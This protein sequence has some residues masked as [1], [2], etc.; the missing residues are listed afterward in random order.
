MHQTLTIDGH[1]LAIE[2][3][4]DGHVLRLIGPDGGQRIEI[5]LTAAGPLLRLTS[6]LK[7]ELSG[8]LDLEAE[9]IRLHGRTGV[10][11]SSGGDVAVYAH[12]DVRLDGTRIRNNC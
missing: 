2:P 3:E 8:A 4:G 1:L 10:T 11:L 5:A 9:T 7:V 12:D 6:G